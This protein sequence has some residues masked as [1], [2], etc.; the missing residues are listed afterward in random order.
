MTNSVEILWHFFISR[1]IRVHLL[2]L[3]IIYYTRKWWQTNMKHWLNDNLY[4]K[5]EVLGKKP[6]PL[7]L[8]S[9]Q[10]PHGLALE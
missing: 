3:E 7:Q 9:P 1:G 6:W 8:C 5:T 10:I 4:K 2:Q